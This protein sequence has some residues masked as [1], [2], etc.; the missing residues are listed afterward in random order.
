MTAATKSATTT[1]LRPDG[2]LA[3][4][5][6]IRRE[7]GLEGGWQC[8]IEIVN[9][10]IVVRPLGAIPDEDLWAYEPETHARLLEAGRQPIGSGVSASP[11]DLRDLVEGRVGLEE[12]LARLQR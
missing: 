10:A 3:V 1:L 6:E 4:P 7:L 12:L 8:S 9:G 2:R 5:E 11:Q